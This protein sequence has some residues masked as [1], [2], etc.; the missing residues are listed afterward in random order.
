MLDVLLWVLSSEEMPMLERGVR[1]KMDSRENAR[2]GEEE[3][4]ALLGVGERK[5]KLI[6]RKV[7]EKGCL[8]VLVTR[9]GEVIGGS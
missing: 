5:G 1:W 9:A 6:C 2:Y 4:S 8:K 7:G 3:A